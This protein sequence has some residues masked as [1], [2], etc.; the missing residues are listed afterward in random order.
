MDLSELDGKNL[1]TI[2]NESR[3]EVA[4][5]LPE[6]KCDSFKKPQDFDGWRTTLYCQFGGN[7]VWR[8]VDIRAELVLNLSGPMAALN[9]IESHVMN[10]LR[11]M[12]ERAEAMGFLPSEKV[13]A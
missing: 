2:V 11:A 6:V 5:G 13:T 7:T 12:K 8:N 10:A 4:P 9:L 1:R 3:M